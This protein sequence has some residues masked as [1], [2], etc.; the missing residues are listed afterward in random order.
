MESRQLAI[1]PAAD[2]E[3]E[4]HH[5]WLFLSPQL[6]DILVSTHFDLS[7]GNKSIWLNHVFLLSIYTFSS[8][9]SRKHHT[10]YYWKTLSLILHKYNQLSVNK[11][12]VRLLWFLVIFSPSFRILFSKL[13]VAL[14]RTFQ[15][16][17]V[18]AV[19]KCPSPFPQ[20]AKQQRTM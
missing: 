11:P 16:V 14:I 17:S 12:I 19:F 13:E 2:P 1:L 6:L 8:K 15:R 5:I 4:T 9:P 3:E 7:G 20:V 18:P 10:F